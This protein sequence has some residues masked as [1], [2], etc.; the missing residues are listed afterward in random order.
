MAPLSAYLDGIT[1]R[2]GVDLMTTLA[3]LLEQKWELIDRRY[4]NPGP[5]E[6]EQIEQL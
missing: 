3:T 2:D 1:Q 5:E 4:E 6:R